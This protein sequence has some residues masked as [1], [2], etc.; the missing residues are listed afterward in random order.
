M[1]KNGTS[2][3]RKDWFC[4]GDY[5]K[6]ANEVDGKETSL[7]KNVSR[8]MKG[9]HMSSFFIASHGSPITFSRS[10]SIWSICFLKT[11]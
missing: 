10:P 1:L 2:D 6:L 9:T 7:P 3:S 11:P 5:K 4:V 8:D